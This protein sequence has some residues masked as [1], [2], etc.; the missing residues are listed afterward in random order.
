MASLKFA[1][2]L[3]TLKALLNISKVNLSEGGTFENCIDCRV[4]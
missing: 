1:S 4:G 3:K 2:G